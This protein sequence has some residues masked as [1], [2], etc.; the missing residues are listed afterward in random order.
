VLKSELFLDSNQ[1][2]IIPV[3]ALIR[4]TAIIDGVAVTDEIIQSGEFSV[5]LIGTGK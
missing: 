4:D 3:T 1:N 5:N 2:F